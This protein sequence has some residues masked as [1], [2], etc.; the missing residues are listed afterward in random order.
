MTGTSYSNQGG[1]KTENNL[2]MEQIWVLK[3]DSL[4]LKEWDKTVL[5]N[6]HDETGL[7][8]STPDGGYV[9]ANYTSAGIG[10]EK[11]QDCRGGY[12]FW[13]IKYEDTATTISPVQIACSD[14]VFCG[15]QCI[16]FYDLSTNSPT[17]WQWSF[18]GA[19]PAT[20]NQQNPVGICYN[21][22]GSFDVSLKACSASGCDSLTLQG[23]I[24][25]FQNPPIP[26]ISLHDD[27]L[28]CTPAFAYQWYLNSGILPGATNSWHVI[29]QS[30]NYFV[31]VTDSNGCAASSWSFITGTPGEI[32]FNE[33]IAGPGPGAN[34]LILTGGH[35]G[36]LLSAYD[37]A[38]HLILK[39]K[40]AG[41][42]ETWRWPA[43]SGVYVLEVQDEQYK[44][45][46]KLIWM[47]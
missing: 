40:L 19:V 38:G 32:F 13:M 31:I 42:Q 10:G 26:V 1:D 20:S 27:T 37:L 25:E 21:S 43:P 23:F 47:K 29:Q 36:M 4:G 7:A 34:D 6:G 41:P 12:D 30:G 44:I 5:T 17:S 35:A 24:I 33:F 39:G 8:C 28:Q 15:K 9:F 16:D 14:T 11:S 2:G 3:T 18:P 46:R 22:F 45:R